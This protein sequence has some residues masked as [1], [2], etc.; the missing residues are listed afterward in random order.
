MR[1]ET[2]HLSIDEYVHMVK[3]MLLQCIYRIQY[4]HKRRKLDSSSLFFG[5]T[6]GRQSA[7]QI[8]ASLFCGCPADTVQRPG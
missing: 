7:S 5:T 2:K 4:Q 3:F 1:E 6:F 8:K